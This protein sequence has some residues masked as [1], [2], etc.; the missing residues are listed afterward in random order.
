MDK[1]FKVAVDKQNGCP[2]I[3]GFV[4]IAP[5]KKNR[6]ANEYWRGAIFCKTQNLALFF[7][8][9]GRYSIQM[10]YMYNKWL[11]SVAVRSWDIPKPL[12]MVQTLLEALGALLNFE[13]N[14]KNDFFMNFKMKIRLF[15][16]YRGALLQICFKSFQ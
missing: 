6:A 10:W 14:V 8:F 1:P 13:K 12:S 16:P 7:S 9:L 5:K 2:Q 11:V 4:Q 15:H 3:Q